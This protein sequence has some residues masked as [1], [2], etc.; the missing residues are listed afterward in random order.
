MDEDIWVAFAKMPLEVTLPWVQRMLLLSA[1]YVRDADVEIMSLCSEFLAKDKL[2]AEAT[3]QAKDLNNS[4]TTLQAKQIFLEDEV[5][6]L[7]SAQAASDLREVTWKKQVSKLMKKIEDLKLF[8]RRAK[9]AAIK[10]V[11]DAKT[12]LRSRLR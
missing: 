4:V 9:Q 11:F 2:I 5:K 10:G 6:T 1:T 3:N 12:N 7:K 8:V